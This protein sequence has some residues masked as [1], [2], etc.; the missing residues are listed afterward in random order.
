MSLEVNWKLRMGMGT[1]DNYQQNFF[2]A[3]FGFYFLGH[4]SLV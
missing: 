4:L 1:E 3:I 2:K